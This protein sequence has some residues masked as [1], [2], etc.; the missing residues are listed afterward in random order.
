MLSHCERL[1]HDARFEPGFV[2]PRNRGIGKIGSVEQ[3]DAI[4][5]TAKGDESEVHFANYLLYLLL[6]V[7]VNDG[8][9][10]GGAWF[11]MMFGVGL[12]VVG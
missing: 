9:I 11:F 8:V 5:K 3:R 7:A 4:H 1:Q 2:S 12:V 6:A 10:A